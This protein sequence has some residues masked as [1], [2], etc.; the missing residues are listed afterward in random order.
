MAA[1]YAN[2]SFVLDSFYAVCR[3]KEPSVFK[4][5]PN[6]FVVSASFIADLALDY[7]D[8]FTCS[9]STVV[10]VAIGSFGFGPTTLTSNGAGFDGY[11]IGQYAGSYG[12]ATLSFTIFGSDAE[13]PVIGYKY[14]TQP[15][16]CPAGQ[17]IVGFTALSGYV[18]NSLVLT[19]FSAVCGSTE[20]L[21]PSPV[22][23]TAPTKTPVKTARPTLT[24]T[25]TPTFK[26]TKTPKPSTAAPTVKPTKTPKPTTPAPT[27]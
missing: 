26:P 12:K 24:P 8:S 25:A 27:A 10:S 23:T 6:K 20:S 3:S 18:Y 14:A 4:C 13:T 17:R 16:P 9:D 7:F 19:V 2:G 1:G 5:P 22:P 21:A 11:S 15:F